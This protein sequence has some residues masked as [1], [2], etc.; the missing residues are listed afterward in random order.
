MRDIDKV[1]VPINWT[2]DLL[3][4]LREHDNLTRKL[5][6]PAEAAVDSGV[7]YA[8]NYL[9]AETQLTAARVQYVCKAVARHQVCEALIL[10]AYR[11]GDKTVLAHTLGMARTLYGRADKSDA[12]QWEAA[13]ETIQRIGG[14]GPIRT[15]WADDDPLGG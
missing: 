4:V 15:E 1:L 14:G 3:H 6:E 7:F 2:R 5:P 10:S 11:G 8:Q 13:A 9:E 12:E